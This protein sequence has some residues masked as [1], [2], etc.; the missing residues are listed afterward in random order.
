MTHI[1]PTGSFL[2]TIAELDPLIC[3]T[4]PSVYYHVGD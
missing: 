4:A 2:A 3:V 1:A